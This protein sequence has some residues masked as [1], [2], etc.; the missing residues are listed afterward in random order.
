MGVRKSTEVHDRSAWVLSLWVSSLWILDFSMDLPMMRGKENPK[1]GR[2]QQG[3]ILQCAFATNPNSK[4]TL[5]LSLVGCP[6]I[7]SSLTFVG[8]WDRNF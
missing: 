2:K 5:A 7:F 8:N 3:G 4:Q 1:G 6:P